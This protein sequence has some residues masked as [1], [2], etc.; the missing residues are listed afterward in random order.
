MRPRLFLTTTLACAALLAAPV[1]S[2]SSAAATPQPVEPEVS[3][4]D[5]PDAA[6]AT[7]AVEV[8][9]GTAVLGVTWE[10]DAAQDAPTVEVRAQHDGEW[11]AWTTVA[12]SDDGPDP[13]T[14][15]ADRAAQEGGVQA[16]DPVDVLGA[17]KVEVRTTDAQDAGNLE[18]ALIDPGESD[19]DAAVAAGEGPFATADAAVAKPSV[20]TRSQWGAVES[21]RSC[22]PSAA[23]S[24]EGVI[25]HHTAGVN[26]YSAAQAPGIMR[27]IYSYHTQ[28]RGWC[29]VGYNVLIDRFGTI[30]EGR[31][32]GLERNIIGAHA[33][34]FNTGTWGVSVMGNYDTVDL[35]AAARAS[36]EKLIAWRLG[37]AGIDPSGSMRLVSAG[38]TKYKSGVAVNLPVIAAHL[39]VGLTSCP[40][41]YYY[42]KLSGI[43]ANVDKLVG[44]TTSTSVSG[45]TTHTVVSGDTLS[46]IAGM[47]GT[48]IDALQTANNLSGTLIRVGQVLRV[49][50]SEFTD[51]A[52]GHSFYREIRWLADEGITLGVGD[53]SV[54]D[55]RSS[56][57]RQHMAAFLYRLAGS[58]AYTPPARAQ[59]T[60]VPK[61]HPFYK[62]ISWLAAK[63]ITKGVGGGRF[64]ARNAVERQQMAGFLFR[65]SGERY[66]APSKSRFSDVATDRALYTAVSWLAARGI[67]EGVSATLFD[68]FAAVERQH[69]AA[70]L[71]RYDH[72]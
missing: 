12:A 29:D 71:Y 62:E 58:P 21:L 55:T 37:A 15:E 31:Y 33:G 63:G 32:G 28:V 8:P 42:S 35:P 40:G 3:V 5:L 23:S 60:D 7:T 14:E 19:A 54:F 48:T 11:G 18:V 49:P 70:F 2:L 47:Y 50:P 20:V 43:R 52:A 34:G 46:K 36:L 30:Y 57:Q 53:G 24:L 56:V 16:T 38:S 10:G 9:A 17:D 13:G 72:R 1:V 64:G 69:M 41:R 59:F 39:D 61:D 6:S 51:V 44:S 65:L 45:A 27:G 4:V 22:T 67:T 68:P 25:V 66:T 26:G